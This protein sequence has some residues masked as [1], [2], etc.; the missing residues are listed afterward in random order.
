MR[1]SPPSGCESGPEQEGGAALGRR[2]QVGPPAEA[3]ALGERRQ[4]HAVPA[5]E[6]LVVE[7]RLRARGARLEQLRADAR[8]AGALGV[9]L[10]RRDQR[11]HRRA[12]EVALLGH[13]PGALGEL[14]VLGREHGAQL[15][16]RPRERRALDAVGVG[17]LRRGEAAVLERELAQ[18]VVED[19]LG[20]RAPLLV[21]RHLPGRQV[22]A[23]EQRVVVEHLLEVRH[24]PDRVDRVA[25]EAAAEL[26]VDAAVG[27]APQRAQRHRE[28]LLAAAAPVHAQQEREHRV[29]RELGRAPE[30]AV[31]LVVLAAQRQQR[32]EQRRLREPEAR[33]RAAPRRPSC[34]LAASSEAWLLDDLA[35]LPVGAGD[36]VEHLPERRQPAAR[37][38]R[39]V[40][41]AVERAAVGQQED[42]HRPAALA[43]LRDDRRHVEAVDVGALL[44][45]DLD[46]DEVLVH[47]LRRRPRPRT[48]RAP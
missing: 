1:Q 46:R 19:A 11:E 23:R 39:E 43:R 26:V 12:L 17:V 25:V 7:R 27:H 13:A 9:V 35:A 10:G 42:G 18:Q 37:L 28:R 32:V 4:R 16:R 6:R 30:A 38:G 45:V 34:R 33:R 24:E 8:E 44:A 20:G 14:G 48:T 15:R 29:R 2:Q 3:R 31:A 41:P 47:E 40:R 22:R 5:R 36:A 21:A